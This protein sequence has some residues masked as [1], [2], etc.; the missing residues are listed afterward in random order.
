M[1]RVE[2]DEV[3][4]AVSADR[5]DQAFDVGILP[6]TPG[7]VRLLLSGVRRFA[8]QLLGRGYCLDL[9]ADTGDILI[10]EGLDDLLRGPGSTGMLR[11]MEM[12]HLATT[13]FQH[14]EHEQYLPRDRRH[15]EEVDGNHLTQVSH[16][17][18]GTQRKHHQER[19]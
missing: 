14:H 5:A 7:A 2:Y 18:R 6:R 19:V 11:H 10:S 17:E 3:V 9:G 15:G 12:Q 16:K 8:N 4:Q 1:P 13:M